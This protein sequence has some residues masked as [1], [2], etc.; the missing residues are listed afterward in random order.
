MTDRFLFEVNAVKA[1]PFRLKPT[2]LNVG[3]EVLAIGAG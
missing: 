1:K 3:A 2:K